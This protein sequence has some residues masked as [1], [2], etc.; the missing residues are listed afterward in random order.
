M[1]IDSLYIKFRNKKNKLLGEL[2]KKKIQ[3]DSFSIISNNCWGGL[4]YQYFD[5]QY[6]SPTI[7]LFFCPEDYLRF[8]SDI[9]YYLGLELEEVLLC[10]SHNYTYLQRQI[11]NGA[12]KSNIVIGKLDNVEIVFLH[13]SSFDE[14][15]SKW[16]RRCS[17]INFDRIIYKFNNN[18][19]FEMRHYYQWQ[20][21]PLQNKIFISNI[22]SLK[23]ETNCFYVNRDLLNNNGVNDT[24][25]YDRDIDLVKL[26]NTCN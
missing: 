8:V 3:N 18:N 6:T 19:G 9:R 11:E 1:L 13:Y 2:R 10:D 5:M 25:Y 17:R 26:I 21:I 12:Y 24:T 4:V 15:R 14:A 22:P 16:S 20:N 23:N 7:G